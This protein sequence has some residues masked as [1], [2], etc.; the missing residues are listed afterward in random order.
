VAKVDKS[1]YFYALIRGATS[2]LQVYL[3]STD[4]SVSVV[5]YLRISMIA[6]DRIST[7]LEAAF[8]MPT[9]S[10]RLDGRASMVICAKQAA[11]ARGD[12]WRWK[13]F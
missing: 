3:S 6:N 8:V 11:Y 9:C 2:V 4:R 10:A 12:K 13:C 7:E 5:D 1:S